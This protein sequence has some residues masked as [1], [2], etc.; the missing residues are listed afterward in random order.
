MFSEQCLDNST[1]RSKAGS[2]LMNITHLQVV[3]RVLCFVLLGGDS[4]VT[5]RRLQT[6]DAALLPSK[7]LMHILKLRPGRVNICL[8]FGKQNL[9]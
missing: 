7:S 2:K 3:S 6:S 5:V 1:Q 4:G 9:N 8:W